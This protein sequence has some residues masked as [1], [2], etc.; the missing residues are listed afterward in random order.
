MQ[1]QKKAATDCAADDASRPNAGADPRE[2]K[3]PGEAMNEYQRVVTLGGGGQGRSAQPGRASGGGLSPLLGQVVT[4]QRDKKGNSVCRGR[5]GC[6][7]G[8]HM[9]KLGGRSSRLKCRRRACA[10]GGVSMTPAFVSSLPWAELPVETRPIVVSLWPRFCTRWGD[11]SRE[12][13]ALFDRASSR[14]QAFITLL[15]ADLFG[16]AAPGMPRRSGR[17]APSPLIS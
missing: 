7:Q 13:R 1:P 11:R 6:R 8:S 10:G 16:S 5:S 17:A 4:L 14:S 9:V 15:W 2:P 3:E 12:R